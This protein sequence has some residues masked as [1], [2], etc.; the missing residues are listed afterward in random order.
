[1]RHLFL[2]LFLGLSA[3][4]GKIDKTEITS[5]PL[6]GSEN[7]SSAGTMGPALVV[8][9]NTQL[10]VCNAN[11]E[12]QLIF[13]RS[14]AV[15][16]T[17]ISGQWTGIDVSGGSKG[18]ISSVV[19][20]MTVSQASLIAA[21]LDNAPSSGI[22][23]SYNVSTFGNGTKYVQ[24]R[25]SS[26][27]VGLSNGIFWDKSQNY[28]KTSES[29]SLVYDVHGTADFGFWYMTDSAEITGDA[30]NPF[31]II[32][33]DPAFADGKMLVFNTANNCMIQTASN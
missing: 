31:A 26:G 30:N 16:A 14:Q 7:Y 19:C 22:N 27:A 5:Q 2:A 4:C 23:F 13:V 8:A 28:Y 33:V 11:S 3:S 21:G 18:L 12:G 24:A 32:Y 15:F 9:D 29:D 1:M 6:P 10:P 20:Q 17:C 25:I